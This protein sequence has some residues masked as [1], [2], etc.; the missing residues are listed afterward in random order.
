[1]SHRLCPQCNRP[2]RL[3]ESASQTAWVDYYRCDGC[4]HVWTYDKKDVNAPPHDVT[5]RPGSWVRQ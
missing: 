3:L 1:M 2:G 4:G 5:L